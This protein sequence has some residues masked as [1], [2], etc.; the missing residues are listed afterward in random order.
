MIGMGFQAGIPDLLNLGVRFQKFGD[1]L[2]VLV[3]PFEAEAEGF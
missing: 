1:G 2:S 3:L